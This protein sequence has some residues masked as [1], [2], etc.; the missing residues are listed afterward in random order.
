MNPIPLVDLKAQY[1]SIE[2]EVTAAV[3]RVLE[4]QAFVNGPETRAFE[5]EFAGFC[6]APEAVAVS[7]GTTALELALQGLG[8]GPGDEVIT[9]S[10]TFMATA[11]AVLRS[12]ATLVLVDVDERSWTM[13]PEQVARAVTP[14]TRAVIPVHIYGN[15]AD[16]P[17]IAAA[18]PGVAMIEDAAQAHGARYHGRPIGSDSAATCYSFYP[19]KTLGAYGDAGAV[20]TADPDLAA[21]IRGLRD[22]GRVAGAKYEHA[23][24]GTNA[25]TSELQAAILR[26]KLGHLREW[27]AARQRAAARYDEA[28]AGGAFQLQRVESWAENTRHLYVVVHR[29]RDRLLVELRGQG[30]STGVHY[31]VPVHRQPALEH[32]RHRVQDGALPVTDELAATCLSLPI[33]PELSDD[34]VARVAGALTAAVGVAAGA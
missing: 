15:P 25:R 3:A 22:H 32:T 8:V 9:V 1:R 5:A 29:E 2:P 26:V 19:G 17:A 14:R 21:R 23:F 12:G 28:L 6:G 4:R 31:P 7:N 30:I 18:A 20:T 33:Y 24:V 11:G 27:I 16:V 10:H 13:S 34:A